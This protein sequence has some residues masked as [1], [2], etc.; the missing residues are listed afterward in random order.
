M[1]L[2]DAYESELLTP[3]GIIF[4]DGSEEQSFAVKVKNEIL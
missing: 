1:R 3:D 4:T 2:F